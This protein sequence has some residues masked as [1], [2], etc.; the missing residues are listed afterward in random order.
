MAALVT[1]LGCIGLCILSYFLP[2]FGLIVGGIIW[3]ISLIAF[4]V[5]TV[6]DSNGTSDML[7]VFLISIFGML[8]SSPGL[9]VAIALLL[10]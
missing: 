10:K 7:G 5:S 6:V 3:G 4:V 9:M 1:I 2:L 8:L